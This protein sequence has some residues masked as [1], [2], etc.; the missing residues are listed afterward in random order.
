MM[1][2][3]IRFLYFQYLILLCSLCCIALSTCAGLICDVEK[4]GA[5]GDGVFKNTQAIQKAIDQCSL[6]GGGTVYFPS[7]RKFYTGAL[8][9]K[10]NI[11]L[12]VDKFSTIIGSV[13]AHDYPVV[14]S[15]CEGVS[16]L[17]YSALIQG[18]EVNNVTIAGEGTIDGNGYVWWKRFRLKRLV[19]VR[20]RLIGF[21]NS[22]Q[23]QI[24][25][26]TLINS[27]FWT[28]H[29]IYSEEVN[30]SGVTITNPSNSPNTDGVDI[31]SSRNVIIKNAS[32]SVGDDCI[33]IK[34]GKN[35][36]G[37]MVNKSSENVL[38]TNC[39]MFHGH[40]GVTIGSETSGGIRNVEISN[41]IFAN[42]DRGI[43]LK[44]HRS[45]GGIIENITYEN[46]SMINV[47]RGIEIDMNYS[48]NGPEPDET[49]PTY[50]RN[51]TLRNV[52]SQTKK[53]RRHYYLTNTLEINCLEQFPCK[54]I[55]LEHV[56]LT[57]ARGYSISNIEGAQ[58]ENLRIS[59]TNRLLKRRSKR[60]AGSGI[61][62]SNFEF[63]LDWTES[64]TDGKIDWTA[65]YGEEAYRDPMLYCK[66]ENITSLLLHNVH[67]DCIGSPSASKSL[68]L[69]DWLLVALLLVVC[70]QCLSEMTSWLKAKQIPRYFRS[71]DKCS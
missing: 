9:L 64:L 17:A 4:Y 33:A 6:A 40:G 16:C 66:L 45:R 7:R 53:E 11:Q 70:F 61:E 35:F 71:N 65:L 50:I 32:I 23:I 27:P 43:R 15:R 19:Y 68:S 46:I 54:D 44:T 26:I 30:I 69:K 20:P 51:V 52:L 49:F 24:S 1:I 3:K 39:S 29:T 59:S 21:T 60:H 13:D 25:Q 42:T 2:C 55:R 67:I 36:D 62:Q 31:D 28:I 56:E 22:R 57:D 48:R 41:C 63:L 10:N 37:R 47:I 58:L 12:Y 14:P 5:I 34:S 38:I 18:D 8:T